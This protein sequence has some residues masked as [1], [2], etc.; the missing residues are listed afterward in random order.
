MIRRLALAL[1]LICWPAA[2][3][4]QTGFTK[5]S[6]Q[7][8]DPNNVVYAGCTGNASFVPAPTATTFP[9]LSGSV[10]NTVVVINSCDSAGNMTITL[11]DN[12]LVSDGHPTGQQASQWKFAI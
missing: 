2:S 3:R 1:G 6:A 5:V 12:N 7:V 11:A 9:T 8:L 10:F 4:A